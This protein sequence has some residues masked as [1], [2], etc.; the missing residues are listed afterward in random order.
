MSNSFE[1]LL[2][3]AEMEVEFV[4]GEKAKVWVRQL[5]IEEYPRLLML[6]EDE[7]G[8]VELYCRVATGG[9]KGGEKGGWEAVPEGWG[10]GLTPAS[11]D[12]VMTKAEEL[13]RDFFYRWLRRRLEKVELIRPG[14]V[15]RM[16][17]G[18][19][20]GA[21]PGGKGPGGSSLRGTAPR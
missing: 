16:V 18:L 6:L 12:A 15:E 13:N 7:V 3:G 20:V 1:T 8:Q 14:L 19:A 10:R 17:E 21:G 4:G 5:A 11:H 2:G 9:D